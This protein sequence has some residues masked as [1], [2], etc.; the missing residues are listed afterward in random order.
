VSSEIS[1]V[2][3]GE[4]REIARVLNSLEEKG[5]TRFERNK[6]LIDAL[7]RNARPER[8]IIGITGP[9]GVG[10][11]T[12]VSRLMKEYR[13]RGKTVGI[14]AVD[15]SSKRSGGSL[16]GDRARI[17]YDPGD[18]G[19][20]I[21]SMAAGS[22]VGGLAWRTRHCL[23]VFEAVYDIVI[24][25]TVGVGQS[26]T[27]IGQAVDTVALIAQP[28]SGDVLQ[29]IKAGIMEI[30]H[31]IVVNKADQKV[32]AVK[33][34][35]DLMV[36]ST[37]SPSALE[38]WKLEIVMASA[39]EG[40]GQKELV[41]ILE[42]HR[43]FLTQRGILEELRRQHRVEWITILFREQFGSF[44][45]E[46]LGGEESVRSLIE[47]SDILNPLE[48]LQMLKKS[49]LQVLATGHGKFW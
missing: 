38:G 49:M 40:W 24:I 37:Y 2:L 39:L 3:K 20:F 19:T 16:L 31:V 18:R 44:G 42:G 34:H 14:I 47:R 32:P 36:A 29:F 13:S 11:S 33:A 23:T 27:E 28:G 1:G 22:H 26:E 8:H 41:D 12:L 21:R 25:E 43:R 5:S 35:N 15:P 10:K 6:A 30:P 45:L 7:S 46:V 17:A 9:P 48:S 4:K